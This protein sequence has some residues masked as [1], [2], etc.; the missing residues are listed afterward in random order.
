MLDNESGALI[1]DRL[2]RI[3]VLDIGNEEKNAV[4]ILH[5][6]LRTEPRCDWSDCLIVTPEAINA[7]PS[8][9]NNARIDD[10]I[11]E[12]LQALSLEFRVALVAGL[13]DKDG[14]NCACLID[15][16]VCLGT[17]S[18]KSGRDNSSAYKACTVNCDSPR[19]HRGVWLSAL[20]CMDAALPTDT[21]ALLEN[22][23]RHQ[24]L[25]ECATSSS[26]VPHVLC[27]PARF[28]RQHPQS[29]ATHWSSLSNPIVVAIANLSQAHPSV[30]RLANEDEPHVYGE[31]FPGNRR[32]TNIVHSLPLRADAGPT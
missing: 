4:D 21:T 16:G 17:L 22:K 28:D 5:E 3:G 23:R 24:F 1:S 8:Y 20:V 30:I 31:V 18:R 19:L 2:E 27:V 13:V 26:A 7:R 11:T 14:Y 15:R 10:S 12:A 6:H 29:V 25:L 32:P 9:S